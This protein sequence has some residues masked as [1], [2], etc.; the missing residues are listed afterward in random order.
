MKMLKQI[1]VSDK[2]W[3][4]TTYRLGME[5]KMCISRAE[6]TTVGTIAVPAVLAKLT[7]VPGASTMKWK[8]V[9]AS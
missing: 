8:R 4:T 7:Q 1:A 6:L 3:I 5:L 2:E 9:L